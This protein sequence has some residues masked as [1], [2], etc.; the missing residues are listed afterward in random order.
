MR[1]L[2]SG[3]ISAIAILFLCRWSTVVNAFRRLPQDVMDLRAD[4]ASS[5]FELRE[6]LDPRRRA[7][8]ASP[9][10]D[11][12]EETANFVQPPRALSP[13]D[14][15]VTGL[16]LLD[17][18][19]LKTKQ[20]AGHLPASQRTISTCFTGSLFNIILKL[21]CHPPSPVPLQ[22]GFLRFMHI[23]ISLARN[24]M[25]IPVESFGTLER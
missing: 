3:S 23:C 15:L 13:E 10:I 1:S 4:D 24:S 18:D 25:S 16:P 7:L 2:L 8:S 17:G 11:D 5:V 21:V 19:A 12:R 14:H 9:I 20:Y 22:C 6:G